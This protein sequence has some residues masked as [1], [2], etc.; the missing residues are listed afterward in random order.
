ML[1]NSINDVVPYLQQIPKFQDVGGRAAHMGLAHIESACH[2]MGNPQDEL[3][4]VHVAGTN[5]KGTVCHILSDIYSRAGY[6]TGLFTSPHLIDFRERIQVDGQ[7][8]SDEGIV[9]FFREYY[10][11]VKRYQLTYFEIFTA[12]AFWWFRKQSVDLALIETGL[13][14]RLDATNIVKPIITSITSVSLDHK[15]Y[16]GTTIRKIATEKA[17]IIKKNKPVIIGA[18]P[19][20][21]V[22]IVKE[23]AQLLHAEVI[24]YS[25]LEPEKNDGKVVFYFNKARK[26]FKTDLPGP[27]NAINLAICWQI[28][29]KLKN[30]FQVSW[31][32]FSLAVEN[33]RV[34]SD[35]RAR[36]EPLI[37]GKDWYFDGAHNIEA[38]KNLK[39]TIRY[40][41]KEDDPIIV[42]S[43]MKD[44]ID[45]KLIKEFSEFKKI[46]YYELNS[47]RAAG[48]EEVSLYLNNVHL[49][50]N[51]VVSIRSFFRQCNTKLVIFTGSFYFYKTVKDWINKFS[52]M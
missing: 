14:G 7:K 5:G 45:S 42:I 9:L 41:K 44:K 15:L 31:K 29:R 2:E 10:E 34:H 23:K 48:Y 39:K 52:L 40:F 27:A 13:G 8:I 24:S 32:Q 26:V 37:N 3:A 38:I 19:A 33:V 51:D 50:S 35:L 17:G 4:L 6:R 18:L 36:F 30:N 1:F 22:S 12:M 47:E 21:A 16:L 20:P 46:F 25:D 49:L 11:I 43:L 28:I